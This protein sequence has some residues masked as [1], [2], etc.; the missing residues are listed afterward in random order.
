MSLNTVYLLPYDYVEYDTC[1][2]YYYP[3]ISTCIRTRKT[4]GSHARIQKNFPAGGGGSEGY[5]GM[6]LPRGG[7]SMH[8]FFSHGGRDPPSRSAHGSLRL[9]VTLVFVP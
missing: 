4:F 1:M 2:I 3:N 8:I 5:T 7:G 9:I 6:C